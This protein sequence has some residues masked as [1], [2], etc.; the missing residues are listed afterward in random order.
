FWTDESRRR[1]ARFGIEYIDIPLK[2]DCSS[3]IVRNPGMSFNL[4]FRPIQGETKLAT[5]EYSRFTL[6][7]RAGGEQLKHYYYAR[8][9]GEYYGLFFPQDY[10]SQDWP[11]L[12]T[13]YLRIHHD[14]KTEKYLNS[15]VLDEIDRFIEKM[16]NHIDLSNDALKLLEKEKLEY[17]YC[18]S[19]N[20][21]KEMTGYLAK[22]TYD[23]A[24]DDIISSFF[25]HYHELT[26]FLVNLKL[27]RLHLYSLPLF[28]EGV[29]VCYGG[30]WGKAPTT[31]LTLGAILYREN[32]V[33]LDSILTMTGFEKSAGSDLAY[34]VAG[35]FTSYIIDEI[36]TDKY[37]DLYQQLSGNFER[38]YALTTDEIQ[39]SIARAA[40]K[41]D[42]NKLRDEF[43]T[44]VTKWLAESAGMFPGTIEGGKVVFEDSD[45]SLKRNGDW[46]TL[47]AVAPPGTVNKGNLL[48]GLEPGLSGKGS[49]LF[50]NQYRTDVNFEGYR[51]GIRFDQNEVGIYDYA[52]NQLLVK[53]IWGMLPS[54]AYYNEAE[55]KLTFRFNKE[56]VESKLSSGHDYKKLSE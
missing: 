22:G 21:V 53:Y 46:Y 32:I 31:M 19:D 2:V 30:R 18:D 54:E 13:K 12:Q 39:Q 17:F 24:S 50:D 42:W 5:D 26:H 7:A 41:D 33:P 27:R 10:Y 25:P 8:R 45:L 23:L 4:G 20:M 47:T 52:T 1:S 38:V 34:P 51:F 37:F 44:Y 36:G 9:F 48:F 15:I 16:A 28:R 40:G 56:V 55:N 11:V 3:P 6:H 49:T 35:L 14:P 43:E 29:A